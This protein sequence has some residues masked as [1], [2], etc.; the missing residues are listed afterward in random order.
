MPG[1]TVH[2]CRSPPRRHRTVRDAFE[3]R[4]AVTSSRAGCATGESPTRRGRCQ[5]DGR[6]HRRECGTR[7]MRRLRSPNSSIACVLS[8]RSGPRDRRRGAGC[9]PCR[10]SRPQRRRARERA[11]DR[12]GGVRAGGGP[13][14]ECGTEPADAERREPACASDARSCHHPAEGFRRVDRRTDLPEYSRSSGANVTTNSAL[15]M[16]RVS[17][18]RTRIARRHA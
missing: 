15:R 6:V 4:G 1:S 14:R 2:V 7:S 13:C 3:L 18:S 16:A 10:R 8:D 12:R 9:P 17:H 5:H 11:D